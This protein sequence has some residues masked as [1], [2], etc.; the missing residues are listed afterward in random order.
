MKYFRAIFQ[1]RE[2]VSVRYDAEDRAVWLYLDPADRPRYSMRMLQSIL[3]TQDAIKNYFRFSEVKKRYEIKYFVL[4]SK[5]K[6][7]YN[8]GGDLKWMAEL[9]EKKDKT[10]LQ[11]YA[12]LCID[13]VYSLALNLEVPLTTITLVQG[14]ALGG[15]FESALSTSVLIAE[16]GVK[17]GFPEIKFNMFPGMGAYTFLARFHG[18]QFAQEVIGSGKIYSSAQMHAFGVVTELAERG[19]GV[20]KVKA[21]MRRQ[22]RCHHG[23]HALHKVQQIHNPLSYEELIRITDLWVETAL[24]IC[25]KDLKMMQKIVNAQNGKKINY[26]KIRAHF[27]RRISD[28]TVLFPLVDSNG[29]KVVEDRRKNCDRRKTA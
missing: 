6:G 20:E 18:M 28:R 11:K 7:I 26:N 5:I 1:E 16:E 27:D 2:E 21:Y 9:I 12:H 19:R 14:D 10:S 4:T 23:L 22:N 24:G 3:E 8:Y 25:D 13:N 17:M 29:N 15:G